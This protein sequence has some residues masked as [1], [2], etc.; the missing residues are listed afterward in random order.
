MRHI[1]IIVLFATVAAEP[2]LAREFVCSNLSQ[3]GRATN[4]DLVAVTVREGSQLKIAIDT[5][6]PTRSSITWTNTGDPELD[7]QPN[8]FTS[9]SRVIER[10]GQ[11]F[12]SLMA[13]TK[14]LQ[15]AGTLII[16]RDGALW[17]TE[18]TAANDKLVH[19]IIQ[20]NCQRK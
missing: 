14:T 1:S 6:K 2:A 8:N 16:A 7:D 12:A 11:I 15:S 5:K 19:Y 4:G 20:G 17:I 18:S 13:D 3:V 10:D 9:R